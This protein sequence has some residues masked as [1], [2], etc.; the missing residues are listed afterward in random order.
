[1]HRV[2]AEADVLGDQAINRSELLGAIAAWYG[3]VD[4]KDTDLPTLVREAL[5]RTVKETDYVSV[6]QQGKETLNTATS[7]VKGIAGYSQV[8][9]GTG[10]G[11]TSS[12]ASQPSH[13]PLNPGDMNRGSLPA[14]EE[15]FSKLPLPARLQKAAPFIFS[16]CSKFLYVGFPFIFGWIMAA[17][18]WQHSD[19]ECPRNLDGI[20]VWFG[21]LVLLF[22][23]LA[24]VTDPNAVLGRIAI[25]VIL[26]VLNLVGFLWTM[27]PSVQQNAGDCGTV[28]VGF[29]SFVWVVI[30][31]CALGYGGYLL[32]CHIRRL[33]RKDDHLQN[34]VIVF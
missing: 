30:P 29:S 33:Q 22:S 19:N 27:D 21:L 13:V 9:D 8:D 28:L 25:L 24:Y 14:M 20:L 15:D 12:Q 10:T 3:N 23:G 16:S 11:P 17:T 1:V 31:F 18:G 4:R 7:M 5:A 6:F 26:G 34:N 2:L 32:A